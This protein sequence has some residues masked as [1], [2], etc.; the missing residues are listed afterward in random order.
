MDDEQRKQVGEEVRAERKRRGWS[1]D[2]LARRAGVS[3][4]TVL[5]IEKAKYSNGNLG[6][7]RRVLDTLG[8]AP[9]G[10][11]MC[12]DLTGLPQDVATFLRVAAPRLGVIDEQKRA[13][14]LADLYPRILN[15]SS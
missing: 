9:L 13:V 10:D 12:L 14:L 8:L 11:Q 4:N 6:K 15:G 2:E 1:Q 7:L 5:A 3:A